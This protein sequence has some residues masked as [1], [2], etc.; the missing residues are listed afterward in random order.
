MRT[1]VNCESVLPEIFSF[2]QSGYDDKIVGSFRTTKLNRNITY[3]NFRCYLYLALMVLAKY[4]AFP[5]KINMAQGIL[6]AISIAFPPF[7][8]VLIFNFYKKA[9]HQLHPVLA[10]DSH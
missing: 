1:H 2:H 8:V 3:G 6:L 5:E 9:I 7:A 4:A 10:H